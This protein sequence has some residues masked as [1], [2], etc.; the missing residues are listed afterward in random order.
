MIKISILCCAVITAM[1]IPRM[2]VAMELSVTTQYK[3]EILVE[4]SSISGA[5]KVNNGELIKG[6][7]L[8]SVDI[9]D[10]GNDQLSSVCFDFDVNA[11]GDV[12]APILMAKSSSPLFDPAG[13]LNVAAYI[14]K[15]YKNGFFR[16]DV[17]VDVNSSLEVVVLLPRGPYTLIRSIYVNKISGQEVNEY[18]EWNYT[19]SDIAGVAQKLDSEYSE[20]FVKAHGD[21]G[22]FHNVDLV[23]NFHFSI[24][25]SSLTKP[26][27][28]TIKIGSRNNTCGEPA[29]L[30]LVDW[31]K[32]NNTETVE[33]AVINVSKNEIYIAGIV[34]GCAPMEAANILASMVDLATNVKLYAVKQHYNFTGNASYDRLKIIE[35]NAKLE[36]GVIVFLHATNAQRALSAEKVIYALQ[37]VNKKNSIPNVIFN[38]ETSPIPFLS[39]WPYTH[40]SLYKQD[41][42]GYFEGLSVSKNNVFPLTVNDLIDKENVIFKAAT[43]DW[44]ERAKNNGNPTTMFSIFLNYRTEFWERR[45]NS[46]GVSCTTV[47]EQREVSRYIKSI[48]ELLTGPYGIRAEDILFY[49]IDEPITEADWQCILM[50]SSLIKKLKIRSSILV[51]NYKMDPNSFL[52]L[53][54][55]VISQ[56]V[57]H[58]VT[59]HEVTA[60]NLSNDRVWSYRPNSGRRSNSE[61]SYFSSYYKSIRRRGIQGVGFWAYANTTRVGNANNEFDGYRAD[62]SFL[63]ESADG[64]V[65]LSLR[66]FYLRFLGQQ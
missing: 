17:C 8:I 54:G 11:K 31:K 27:R 36:P 56:I 10:D 3:G 29:K 53:D 51:T 60:A 13:E 28:P 59:H 15:D 33:A 34:E 43:K 26:E 49:P 63:Y 44:I 58:K 5:F 21:K 65:D 41:P 47:Q 62:F 12:Y 7:G 45:I 35:D 38:E 61:F 2:I 16:E 55:D 37:G 19:Q 48:Y 18:I 40:D 24:I 66:L 39:M 22:V 1:F 4:H 46:S 57:A 64:R 52:Q 14:T 42:E 25:D 32:L 9:S 23:S 30:R 20:R 50:F 6:T